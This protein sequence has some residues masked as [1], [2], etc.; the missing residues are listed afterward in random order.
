M[1]LKVIYE[2]NH[3]IVM[4]NSKLVLPCGIYARWEK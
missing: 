2:D 4:E 1:K 3:I